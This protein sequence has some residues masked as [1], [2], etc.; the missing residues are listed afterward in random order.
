MLHI[1]IVG[2]GNVGFH[3]AQAIAA[4]PGM[5]IIEILG[6]NT[7]MT[8]FPTKIST[9]FERLPETDLILI[10]V[11]DHAIA[12]VIEQIPN[13]FSGIVAHTAAS[14]PMSV[15]KRF[16]NRGVFYPLQTFSKSKAIS[17]KELPVFLESSN[18]KAQN[19][20]EILA[21]K[22][23]TQIRYTNSEQRL[24]LHLAAVFSCNF[25]NALFACAED[26]LQCE[27][28][29]FDVLKPL[30]SETVEKAFS[31]SPQKAQTG[32]ALRNDK[33]TLQSHL[34]ALSHPELHNLY[35]KLTELIQKQHGIV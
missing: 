33:P 14:V 10:A 34:K 3:L 1:S 24:K 12:S 7:D 19:Q 18:E 13:T 27:N 16:K 11:A 35:Q 22:L 6:R 32:P 4:C 5:K 29:P 26:I 8:G 2:T 31:L 23:Q 30:I 15:L 21:S 9:H 17:W 20:L 28:V 25:V